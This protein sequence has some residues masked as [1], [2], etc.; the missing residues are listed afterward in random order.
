M[1]QPGHTAVA[2]VR[3]VGPR[4]LRAPGAVG[5]DWCRPYQYLLARKH[6]IRSAIEPENLRNEIKARAVLKHRFDRQ[7]SSYLHAVPRGTGTQSTQEDEHRAQWPGSDRV[8]RVASQYVYAYRY[9][10]SILQ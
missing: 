3:E 6:L 4:A 9:T 8:S 2:A 5:P 7:T 10:E 1:Q